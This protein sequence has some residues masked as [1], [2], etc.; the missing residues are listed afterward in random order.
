MTVL[1]A[2]NDAPCERGD[3]V[4]INYCKTINT[5]PA[6]C[7]TPPTRP[8]RWYDDLLEDLNTM[9][10]NPNDPLFKH[11]PKCGR[12]KLMPASV[13]S[14]RCPACDFVFYINPAAAVAGLVLNADRELLAVMRNHDPAKGTWDLPGGFIDPG[15]TYEEGLRR[16]LREELNL[17]IIA[18]RYFCSAPNEYVYGSVVYSTVD[19]AFICEIN[20][21]STLRIDMDEIASAKFLPLSEIKVE[22]FGLSSIRMIVAK[23]LSQYRYAA[24][25]QPYFSRLRCSGAKRI[26]IDEELL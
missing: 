5:A 19:V 11:C 10:N 1:N 17:D 21:S 15:E 22:N 12:K 26:E 16:E 3:F 24:N 8:A 20:T 7:T 13:K 4:G 6:C 9:Q 2:S 18:V 23:Y 14:F 25:A